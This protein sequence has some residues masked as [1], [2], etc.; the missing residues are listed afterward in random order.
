LAGEN[1]ESREF[2]RLRWMDFDD[3]VADVWPAKRAP[4][5]LARD[6]ARAR[7]DAWL[8]KR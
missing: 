2:D 5:A 7:V 3:I 8:A 1:G 6:V 4:Y